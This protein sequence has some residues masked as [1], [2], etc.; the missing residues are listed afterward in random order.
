MSNQNNIVPPKIATRFLMLFLR[1]ELAEEVEGDLEEQFYSVLE[2]SGKGKAK[3]DY[4]RQV[5]MYLRP[6]AIKKSKSKISKYA[7]RLSAVFLDSVHHLNVGKCEPK[8]A[9]GKFKH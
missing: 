9:G 5:F 3:L 6:F 4:W 7:H 1:K 2:L 8:S